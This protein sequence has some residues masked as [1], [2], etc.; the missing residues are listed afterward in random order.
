MISKYNYSK[1]VEYFESSRY[2]E[3]EEI[4]SHADIE[5]M[6]A[7]ELVQLIAFKA[8]VEQKLHKVYWSLEMSQLALRVSAKANSNAERCKCMALLYLN[9]AQII[10]RNK[11][12]DKRFKRAIDLLSLADEYFA[13]LKGNELE[14]L[15][16]KDEK[17]RTEFEFLRNTKGRKDIKDIKQIVKEYRTL[18]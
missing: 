15:F 13:Q 2:K 9:E 5:K 1:A 14:R 8:L 18:N 6:S 10:I 17:L 16:V 7:E 12:D 3:L 4:I 11:K